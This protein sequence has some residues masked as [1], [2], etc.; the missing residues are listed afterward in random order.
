VVGPHGGEYALRELHTDRTYGYDL[1]LTR[2]ST[3]PRV[4]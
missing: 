4:T 1:I 3:T 2:R